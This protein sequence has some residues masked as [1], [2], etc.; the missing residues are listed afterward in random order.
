MADQVISVNKVTSADNAAAMME[1]IEALVTAH[2]SGPSWSR[3]SPNWVKNLETGEMINLNQEAVKILQDE[4]PRMDAVATVETPEGERKQ[5]WIPQDAVAAVGGDMRVL[6]ANLQTVLSEGA[7]VGGM[8][9]KVPAWAWVAG[10]AAALY[11]V[12]R[13]KRRRFGGH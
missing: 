6:K 1:K 5:V 9:G 4:G 10:G 12:S 11:L 3:V 8:L 7:A 13:P 2:Y